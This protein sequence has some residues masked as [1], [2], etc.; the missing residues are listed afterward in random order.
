MFRLTIVYP[1][2]AEAHFDFDYYAKSH[3]PMVTFLIGKSALRIEVA[4]G[5][6]GYG[7]S[8]APYAAVG[9]IYLK[10]LDGLQA[11]FQSHGSRIQADVLKYTNIA[12][13]VNIEE[14]LP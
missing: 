13:V 14:M 10:D 3:M 7:G 2:A 8:P 4:K 6:L 9:H 5:L 11:A 1:S 12:P